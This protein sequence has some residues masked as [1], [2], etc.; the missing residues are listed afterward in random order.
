MRIDRV[1]LPAVLALSTADLSSSHAQ[2]LPRDTLVAAGEEYGANILRDGLLGDDYRDLWTSPIRVE[3]LD[4]HEIGGGLRVVERGGGQQ[5]RSL[6][7]RD[8][9]EWEYVFRSVNKYPYLADEPALHETLVAD[10]VRDQV[11]SLHPAAALVADPLLEAAGVLHVSPRLVVMPDD[12]ALGEFREEF[13]GMLGIFEPRPDEGEDGEGFGGFSRVVGT[14]RLLE[15]LEEDPD[16]RVDEEAF[17]TARLMDLLLGD[18]DRHGDQWRW[19]GEERDGVLFWLPIPR[20]RD[21]AFVDYDGLLPGL[22]AAFIPNAVSFGPEIG[23]VYGLTL[24]ARDLDRRLLSRV[25]GAAWDSIAAFLQARIT[26]EV[27]DEAVSRM[28]PEYAERSAERIARHLRSRRAELPEAARKL[29]ALFA[30]EVD[31]HATDE[32]DLALVERTGEEEVEVSLFRRG[33]GAARP[34]GAP[35]YRRRFSGS[36]T[37]E[38]RIFLHGGDDYALVRGA[39]DHSLGVRVI[40]GGGDDVLVD[41]SSVRGG[42]GTAFYDERGDNRFVSSPRTVVVEEPYA[43]PE[44]PRTLGGE[45]FRDWGTRRSWIFGADYRNPDGPIL[46]AGRVLTRFG[47]RRYPFA[48]QLTGRLR[49]APLTRKLGVDLAG[50]FRRDG[51]PMAYSFLFRASQ[52]ETVRFYGYGNDTEARAA[53]S[54]YAIRQNRIEARAAATFELPLAGRLSVGPVVKYSDS[55]LPDGYPVLDAPPQGSRGFGQV[56]GAVEGL[57]D[58]RDAVSFPREGGLLSVGASA[59]PGVWDAAGAF[60]EAHLQARAYLPLP[61]PREATLAVR[62]GGQRVWGEFP[63]HEAAFLGGSPTLRGYA[64]QRFAGD[65]LLFG[66]AELRAL[67]FPAELVVRGDLGA[68]VLADA[69]RVS[70]DGYSSGGWHTS[71][72]GGLWF[73][74]DIRGN[75][76]ALTVSYAH[77]EDRGRLYFDFGVPF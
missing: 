65:G 29:Y 35:F 19:A 50:D 43:A 57:L 53:V 32:A 64:S 55:R 12:P 34:S 10:V 16:Q 11:S 73:R 37:R 22:A 63:F 13:A 27:I 4:L 33:E 20:D 72:G 61:A 40:G 30:S 54:R 75:V 77:G 25:G 42:G 60:G 68:L 74:F 59:Y 62:A 15:R 38:V 7:L 71:Y 5:T 21:Y 49:V 47:F 52:L 8:A 66:A 46:A 48:R 45:T 41:S 6:R 9:R 23:S 44:T 18:W 2:Q 24:N 28:P 58:G 70:V 36:E 14:E 39:V 31:V 69:G 76:T 1:L 67:L 26:D 56:G 17:A 3:V 51:K